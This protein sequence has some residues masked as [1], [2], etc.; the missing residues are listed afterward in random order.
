M[1]VVNPNLTL[2]TLA[3]QHLMT[4]QSGFYAVTAATS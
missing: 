4:G 1:P 2:D 3:D